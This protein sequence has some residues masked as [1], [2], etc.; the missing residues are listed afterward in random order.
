[1]SFLRKTEGRVGRV[2][3]SRPD[4]P[5]FLEV[6]V[7]SFAGSGSLLSSPDRLAVRRSTTARCGPLAFRPWPSAVQHPTVAD[8]APFPPSLLSLTG[9]VEPGTSPARST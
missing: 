5:R 8:Y 9:A 3:P 6:P 4:L 1:M 2:R 7:W